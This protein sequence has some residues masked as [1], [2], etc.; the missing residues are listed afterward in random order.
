MRTRAHTN[1]RADEDT[2]TDLNECIVKERNSAGFLPP[3]NEEGWFDCDALTKLAKQAF[4]YSHA[5][6]L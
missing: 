6:R 1:A 5:P 4:G 2:V 3:S